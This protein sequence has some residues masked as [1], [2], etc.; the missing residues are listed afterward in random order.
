MS[1]RKRPDD[2]FAQEILAHIEL[3]TERLIDEGMPPDEARVAARRRFGNV[4]S[5]RERYYESGRVLW[6]DHLVQDVRCAARS[7]RRYPIASLVAVLS[8]AFGIGATTVT[9]TIRNVVFR[10]PPAAYA[11]PEQLSVVQVGSPRN[12]IRG[13]A[14][15]A[16]PA[17][18][19]L[20]WREDLGSAIAAAASRGDQTVRTADR[21]ETVRERAVSPE[22][23]SVLGVVPSAGVGFSTSAAA[24]NGPA[25]AILS[26]RAWQQLFDDR[27]DA[28]GQVFWIDDRPHTV[29]GVMPRNFWHSEMDSPIW[30]VLDVRTL[31]PDATVN[32]IARRPPGVT[33]AMLE[34]RLQA[35]LADYASQLP[36]GQRQ[37]MLKTSGVEGTP[38]GHQMSFVLPYVL[39]TAVLLTLLIACANVAILMMAQWT[40]REQEIAIRASI[41]AT[42]GRL[43]RALLTESVLMAVC[44]GA[45][46]IATTLALRGWIVHTQGGG[47]LFFALEI[48]PII[49]V[50]T[51]AIT[52]IT[53]VLAGIMPAIY[54]TRRLHLNPLRTIASSDV[55]R[56]RWR[57]SLV[58]LEISVTIALLVVTSAMIEGYWRTIHG[59]VGYETAPLMTGRVD[60][61]QGVPTRQ[62]L[63]TLARMP[64]V[65]SAS[66]STSVPTRAAG[67]RVP[68]T[69]KASDSEPVV[70]ERGD[71][72]EGFFA[73]LGVPLRAGRG[74]SNAD[75]AASRVAVVNETLARQLFQ[76]RNAVGS[77]I[78]IEDVAH[79]VVGVVADYGSSPFR[80][81][82][83]QPR[84]FVPLGADSSDVRH[85]SFLIRTAGD[86][87]PLVRAARQEMRSV[88]AGTVSANAETIDQV[89]EI[90][91]QEMMIGT[92]PLFPLVSIGLMLTMA[93]IY[94]VLAFAIARRARE[95]A[96]RVAVGASGRDVVRVV[97]S[98]A[99]RLVAA[100]AIL[101]M[102]VM[103]G[104]AR[105]VRAGGG[106]GSIWDPSLQ[107]FL[108]PVAV[109]AIVGAIATWIPARRAL[110][111]DPVVLLRS[112]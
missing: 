12:P 14:G 85:M 32:V 105:V 20:K 3:E 72:T 108:L 61:S 80:A 13:P 77:R 94:G 36:A 75:T 6:L 24:P 38:I 17:P 35:G 69:A 37:L 8:L 34:A 28:I 4:T 39:G 25:P 67:A 111:I 2:D 82:I 63:E 83:P 70:A 74:F 53:G 89:I 93:G 1:T 68:V 92:A 71:I 104:L 27:T 81:A 64:G 21:T 112:Q 65:V 9:L 44:G 110:A 95:L 10:K 15:N 106:A 88:G 66:A 23:F 76:D 19:Y 11:Q 78:W 97:A 18:L 29:I 60:N 55:V 84:V 7:M 30:T 22:L 98:H 99:L 96:V 73:T 58:V 57:H 62:I 41:G 90:M 54:E 5:A 59:T 26:A 48:D 50:E 51:A 91:G 109:V 47:E 102:F 43:V 87:S 45:L 79:D 103:L 52:L 31:M 49:F 40:A 33:P 100:G 42:R 86:P 46:G 107:A 56:Q 101:G 16:V